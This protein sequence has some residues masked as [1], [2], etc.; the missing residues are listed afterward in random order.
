[1]LPEVRH[2]EEGS[3]GAWFME[4]DGERLGEMTYSRAGATRIIIDHT[5]VSDDLRGQGAGRA[6]VEA[7]V[8]WARERELVILPLC[9]FARATFDR[10][11]EWADVLS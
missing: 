8:V 9:P 11:P 3:K 6:L 10:H 7:S 4:R 2:E 5:E 1:M